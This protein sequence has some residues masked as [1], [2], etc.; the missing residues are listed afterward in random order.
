M[1]IHFVG[2]GGRGVSRLAQIAMQM[3]H[4]VSGSDKADK[5]ILTDLRNQ[6]IT[7]FNEHNASNIEGVNLII[8]SVS[9]AYDNVELL[10]A[11]ERCIP[12]FP[13][14]RGLSKL[15]SQENQHPIA[16]AGTYGKTTTTTL[17][18][19]VLDHAGFD[20]TIYVGGRAATL[21]GQGARVGKGNFAVIEADEYYGQF[22]EINA[23]GIILTGIELNHLDYYKTA[24]NMYRAFENFIEHNRATSQVILV[25]SDS[26]RIRDY[27]IPRQENNVVTYGIHSGEWHA[28]Q[29][30]PSPSREAMDFAVNYKEGL[31]GTFRLHGSGYHLIQNALGVIA[32]AHTLGARVEDIHNGL[33]E[34]RDPERHFEHKYSSKYIVVIDDNARIPIQ[35]DA[36]IQAARW[37]FPDNLLVIIGGFWGKLNPRELDIYAASL[38]KSDYVFLMPVGDASV[39]FG[40]AEKPDADQQLVVEIERYGKSKAYTMKNKANLIQVIT[41]AVQCNQTVTVMTLGYDSYSHEFRQITIDI[42]TAVEALDALKKGQN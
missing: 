22:F 19:I 23:A 9:I 2:I 12:I 13:L 41:N 32:M 14:V 5:S 40:G 20:P 7:I 24:E 11:R 8:H 35:I 25:C 42:I 3:G 17:L 18:A 36:A 21:R 16:V 39:E 6:G 33:L 28:S 26:P 34:Y 27:I 10:A 4:S 31:I 30:R 38:H 15:L 29:I 37:A 1:K